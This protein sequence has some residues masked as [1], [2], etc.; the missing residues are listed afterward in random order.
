MRLSIRLY[1]ATDAVA[2][3]AVVQIVVASEL[4]VGVEALF[5]TAVA[6]FGK[7]WTTHIHW[8]EFILGFYFIIEMM[9]EM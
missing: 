6:V 4:L 3:L 5:V 8:Y 9:Y 2:D 7:F 1:A